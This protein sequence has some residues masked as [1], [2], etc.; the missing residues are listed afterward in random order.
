M[1]QTPSC[2]LYNHTNN[3]YSGSLKNAK[4][5]NKIVD[6]ALDFHRGD[7]I[8]VEFGK[9]QQSGRG[10]VILSISKVNP[11]LD[12][13]LAPL[14]T[15]TYKIPVIKDTMTSGLQYY[16]PNYT[17]NREALKDND[18]SSKSIYNDPKNTSKQPPVVLVDNIYLVRLDTLK[19]PLEDNSFRETPVPKPTL[20]VCV[21]R[22]YEA[23][24]DDPNSDLAS[25]IDDMLLPRAPMWTPPNGKPVMFDI[26]LGKTA[27]DADAFKQRK[28]EM[29]DLY[30]KAHKAIYKY[31]A[32]GPSD[33][34]KP[35]TESAYT[36]AEKKASEA[37]SGN[38]DPSPGSL[39]GTGGQ[40]ITSQLLQ[41]VNLK[42]SGLLCDV[43]KR[44]QKKCQ[45]RVEKFCKEITDSIVNGDVQQ[46]L[47]M[48]KAAHIDMSKCVTS[49]NDG[50]ETDATAGGSLVAG[51]VNVDHKEWAGKQSMGCAQ[52][53][54]SLA[55]TSQTMKSASCLVNNTQICTGSETNID[56][57]ITFGD[58]SCKPNI[59]IGG[60]FNDVEIKQKIKQTYNGTSSVV[61]NQDLSNTLIEKIKAQAQAVAMNK[62]SDKT[63]ESSVAQVT[64]GIIPFN[65]DLDTQDAMKAKPNKLALGD[66]MG[67]FC[68]QSSMDTS[69]LIALQNIMYNTVNN[70]LQ[71]CMDLSIQGVWN[72]VKIDQQIDSSVTFSVANGVTTAIKNFDKEDIAT[73]IKSL[74][75]NTDDEGG[76]NDTLVVVLIVVGC[77]IGAVLLG[78]LV[79]FLVK[80]LKNAKLRSKIKSKLTGMV[81]KGK[82]LLSQ[83]KAKIMP[84]N[85]EASSSGSQLT[86]PNS[87]PLG[88]FQN[89]IGLNKK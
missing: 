72:T 68:K 64:K 40:P 1:G 39:S 13:Y 54:F 80:L 19:T 49:N 31:L 76:T 60:W 75:S 77:V 8:D 37:A 58:S 43:N 24:Q 4:T 46:T 79:Y 87:G 48:A 9:N 65:P 71:M 14:L 55:S 88:V 29:D 7:R 57:T 85:S 32:C 45:Q 25:R 81:S 12:H 62:F 22:V 84:L 21:D 44:K 53:M 30:Q 20:V 59:S 23:K 16:L 28:Q 61:I 38:M 47:K 35:L 67:D 10:V 82:Q 41:E 89:M 6:V 11:Y 15:D 27:P 36:D 74:T 18:E 3:A 63:N 26:V 52:A 70:S 56:N 17:V 2:K 83:S 86:N 78:V 50:S 34:M 42:D 73:L 51:V 66:T 5:T 69:N 33:T